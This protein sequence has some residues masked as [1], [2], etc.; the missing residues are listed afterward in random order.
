MRLRIGTTLRGG[1][2][3]LDVR[4]APHLKVRM[5][6]MLASGPLVNL[7][8]GIV[9]VMAALQDSVLGQSAIWRAALIGFGAGNLIMALS[10][11]WP[12][13]ARSPLGPMPTDGAQILA[14]FFDAPMELRTRRAFIH[15]VRAMY[16]YVDRDYES[17]KRE[18]AMAESFSDHV[19]LTADVLA[20]RAEAF[21]ES[22][23]P[24]PHGQAIAQD[25]PANPGAGASQ[26]PESFCQ[27][28]N[29]RV[30]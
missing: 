17:A 19:E 25:S 18:T 2:T 5:I 3:Y 22:G 6:L 30:R 27:R 28:N 10:S 21:S 20:L 16:A 8:A 24:R 26:I 9:A 14:H 23:E 1:A 11:L 12:R 29:P 4:E 15:L 7:A 13:T